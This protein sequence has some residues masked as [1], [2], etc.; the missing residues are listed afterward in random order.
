M[1]RLYFK[2]FI[3]FNLVRSISFIEFN[4]Y[5]YFITFK[6]DYIKYLKIY[7]I[8]FKS[9]IFIIFL[10][11]KIYLESL[12]YKINRIYINNNNEYINKKFINYFIYNDIR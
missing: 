5:K 8:R 4:N 12:E 6:N 3:Y 7:Y 1:I 10:R 11:F 9:E 2:E